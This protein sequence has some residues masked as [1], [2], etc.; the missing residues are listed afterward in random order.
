MLASAGMLFAA[1]QAEGDVGPEYTLRFGHLANEENSWHRAAVFFADEVRERSGGRIDVQVYPNEQLGT[2]LQILNAI[3]AGTADMAITGGSLVNWIP[4]IGV[5]E[6]PATIRDQDHLVRVASG[7]IGQEIE[8]EIIEKGG[9]RPIAYFIRGPRNL[10]SNRPI[11]TPE[12]AEGLIVR[13]PNSPLYVA[14]WEEVGATPT[15]MAFSEVFTS[16]QQGTIHAQENPLAL[17]YSAGF[18]E[19]QDY[20]NVTEHLR[21]W[22]YVVI[23]EEKFQSM[24]ADLQQIV[25][26][27]GQEMQEYEH[28]LFLEDEKRLEDELKARGM[29]FITDVD[30]E[31]FTQLGQPGIIRSLTPEQ[32]ELWERIVAE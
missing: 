32:R 14:F 7:P 1:G 3:Q 28:Q 21:T 9:F 25:I 4:R 12:D 10:T 19:V 18:Y 23:G 17:I 11:R 31:A 13:V 26:D 6:T 29:T 20:V 22:I 8:A 27:V 16:L 30:Q 24:P 5:M 2:E 15:P